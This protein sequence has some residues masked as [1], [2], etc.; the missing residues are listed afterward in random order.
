[1]VRFQHPLVVGS[2]YSNCPVLLWLARQCHEVERITVAGVETAGREAV[3]SDVM[4]SWRVHTRE[5]LS[6]WVHQQG[7]QR[8]SA[9]MVVDER[10]DG[11][12]QSWCIEDVM[13]ARRIAGVPPGVSNRA[14]HARE[15]SEDQ[16]QTTLDA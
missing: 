11:R 6:E 1:M 2:S 15:C 14:H 13:C 5:D 9:R 12:P 4:R 7:F 3:L 10:R 8:E 16:P